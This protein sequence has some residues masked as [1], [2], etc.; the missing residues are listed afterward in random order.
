MSEL[1]K[2]FREGVVLV[3][4]EGHTPITLRAMFGQRK[5]P[6]RIFSESRVI[7]VGYIKERNPQLWPELCEGDVV[8]VHSL[9]LWAMDNVTATRL[10]E[11]ARAAEQKA[12]RE[13]VQAEVRPAME[14]VSGRW[15]PAAVEGGGA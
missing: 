11:L 2:L 14:L 6:C 13:A 4:P 10:A 3:V 5:G 12:L 8:V 15:R 1:S 9:G 7:V